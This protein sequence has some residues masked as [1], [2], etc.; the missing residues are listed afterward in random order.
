MKKGKKKN[1]TP[2]QMQRNRH[3]SMILCLS[4]LEESKESVKSKVFKLMLFLRTLNH[5]LSRILVQGFCFNPNRR[6]QQQGFI[7]VALKNIKISE[8]VCS[9]V[10]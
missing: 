7:V 9:K 10:Q 3:V 2:S 4:V 8:I 5:T 1:Q 6:Y